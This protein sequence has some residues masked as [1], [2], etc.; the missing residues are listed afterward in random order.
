VI[1]RESPAELRKTSRPD[2]SL[3]LIDLG[4]SAGTHQPR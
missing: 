3:A 4:R 1:I 2:L